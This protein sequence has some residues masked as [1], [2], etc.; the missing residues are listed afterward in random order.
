MN[1]HNDLIYYNKH[2]LWLFLKY[3]N[4]MTSRKT[5]SLFPTPPK[6]QKKNIIGIYVSYIFSSFKI[7]KFRLAVCDGKYN[8]YY[9]Q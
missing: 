7:H 8:I 5:I 6:P 9:I 1:D 2:R 3:E 4:Q